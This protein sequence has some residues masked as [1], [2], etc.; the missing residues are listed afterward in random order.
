MADRLDRIEAILERTAQ[1]AEA[2]T[3]AIEANRTAIAQLNLTVNSLVQIVKIHQPNF[4][5]IVTELREIR[6]E[7]RGL[8]TETQRILEH[9][10]GR[11]ENR[12]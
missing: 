12:E 6:T 3:A 4:E 1:R 9:L 10:F 2:N 5:G 7:I 8:R 11:Q